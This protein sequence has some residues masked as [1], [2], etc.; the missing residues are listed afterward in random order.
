MTD[1]APV[2]ISTIAFCVLTTVGFIILAEWS[3][4]GAAPWSI[5]AGVARG[6]QDW[7]DEKSQPPRIV[8]SPATEPQPPT[9]TAA[10]PLPPLTTADGLPVAAVEEYPTADELAQFEVEELGTRRT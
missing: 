8:S 6:I 9:D 1:L 2:W 3:A 7:A 10:M 4:G 5:A